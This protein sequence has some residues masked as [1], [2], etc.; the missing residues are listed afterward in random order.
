MSKYFTFTPTHR[1][2]L[3]LSDVC[4]SINDDSFSAP[5]AF[6]ASPSNPPSSGAATPYLTPTTQTPSPKPDQYSSTS[7]LA[8]AATS[9]FLDASLMDKYLTPYRDYADA[10]SLLCDTSYVAVADT[11]SRFVSFDATGDLDEGPLEEEEDEEEDENGD[12]D[13][14]VEERSMAQAD[15]HLDMLKVSKH[16]RL[17]TF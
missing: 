15:M 2:F 10:S 11:P 3:W 9:S 13:K 5:D 1:G 16:Y 17:L 12:E 6:M 14:S 7:S 4:A 8:A